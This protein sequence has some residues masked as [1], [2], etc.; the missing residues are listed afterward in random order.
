MRLEE[1]RA[2]AD[3]S[4]NA[5]RL[6]AWEV[7]GRLVAMAGWPGADAERVAGHLGLQ[8]DGVPRVWLRVEPGGRPGQPRAGQKAYRGGSPEEKGNRRLDA[9]WFGTSHQLKQAAY[10]GALELAGVA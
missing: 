5:G 8:A 3:R 7:D 2:R 4:I 10:C 1:P 9:V 6:F